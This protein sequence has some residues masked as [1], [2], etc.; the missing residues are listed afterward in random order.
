MVVHVWQHEQGSLFRAIIALGLACL[1]CNTSSSA[2][3]REAHEQESKELQRMNRGVADV[4]RL[5]MD[6]KRAFAARYRGKVVPGVGCDVC[7]DICEIADLRPIDADDYHRQFRHAA[8]TM[9]NSKDELEMNLAAHERWRL[10]CMARRAPSMRDAML[11]LIGE[12]ESPWVCMRVAV[13]LLKEGLAKDE[14]QRVIEELARANDET[15]F[16]ARTMSAK[17]NKVGWP[18]H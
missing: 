7:A 1:C 2:S 16:M 14:P 9:L 3:D 6:T 13:D 18:G 12:H 5:D 10:V 11:D 4:Q 8:E 15:G 17:W